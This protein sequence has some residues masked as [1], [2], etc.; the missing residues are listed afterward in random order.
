MENILVSACLLGD[1]VKYNGKNNLNEAVLK[2]KGKYNIIKI[3]PEVMGGLPIPRTPSE[4][5][6]DKVIFSTG[7]DVTLNFIKGKDEVLKLVKKYNIKKAVLKERSPSCAKYKV[8]DGTFS[9]TLIDGM[10]VTARAL[11][12]FNVLIFDENEIDK[13]L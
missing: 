3:C 4:I 7:E 6:G 11:E 10:G 13:L 12:E 2:L 9:N 1:N 5:K 8:H